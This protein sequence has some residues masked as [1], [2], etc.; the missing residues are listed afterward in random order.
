MSDQEGTKALDLGEEIV[1]RV[2]RRLSRTEFDTVEEYVT[3]V[4]EEVLSQVEADT[5]DEDFQAVDEAQVK[6]RL[7]SLGYLNE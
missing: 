6:D 2:E 5:E 3:Y 4:L 1:S 7:R